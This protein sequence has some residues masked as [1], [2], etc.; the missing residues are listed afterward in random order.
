MNGHRQSADPRC[1]E[2]IGSAGCA[3]TCRLTVVVTAARANPLWRIICTTCFSLLPGS[4][5][6]ALLV[7][8]CGRRSGRRGGEWRRLALRLQRPLRRRQ[9]DELLGSLE[10]HSRWEQEQLN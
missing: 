3:C 10:P 8:R 6:V 5:I 7:C 4:A 2:L 9:V 1:S